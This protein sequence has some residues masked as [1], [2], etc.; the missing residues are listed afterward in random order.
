MGVQVDES[1]WPLVAVRWEGAVSD[2]EVGSFLAWMDYWLERGRRFGVLIDARGS[3]GLSARQRDQVVAHLRSR[4]PRSAK[5]LVQ[6]LVMDHALQRTLYA[7]IAA[8]FPYPFPSKV[9]AATP[10]ARAWIERELS[11]APARS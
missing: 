7:V 4:A 6:A 11:T 3:L 9:F 1:Q 10:S 5:L 8:V 2:A